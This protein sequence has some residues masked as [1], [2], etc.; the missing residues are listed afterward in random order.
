MLEV[1]P[2]SRDEVSEA[3]IGENID[4]QLRLGPDGEGEYTGEIVRCYDTQGDRYLAVREAQG[5]VGF[6]FNVKIVSI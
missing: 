3:D 5:W 4:F 6:S 1:H 2:E